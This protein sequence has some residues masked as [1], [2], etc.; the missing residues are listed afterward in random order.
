[1]SSKKQT[2]PK[3]W[4]NAYT[5]K[6]GFA[7]SLQRAGV[8]L[9]PIVFFL[10]IPLFFAIVYL[11]A[12]LENVQAN[13]FN[14]SNITGT[15][16]GGII[17]IL[18]IIFPL[19]VLGHLFKTAGTFLKSFYNLTEAMDIKQILN[20]RVFGRTPLPPPLS[21]VF[22]F[23]TVTAKNGKLDPQENWQT[24]IG[25]P[26]KLK[27]EPGYAIYLE[28]GNRFSR[29]V[30]QGNSFLELHETVK[31][32]L[33]TGP[34]S[35]NFSVSAWTRDGIHVVIKAKGEYFLGSS[36]RNKGEENILF[37]YDPA[38]A[39]KAVEETFS[40][41]RE[42]HEWLKAVV[43]K[44]QGAFGE[45]ISNRYLDEIFIP[46]VNG[47]QLLSTTTMNNLLTD[48]KTSLQK[49]GVYLSHLQ[50]TDVE[51]PE[52]IK[53]QRIKIW[54]TGHQTYA[55]VTES[56]V[57]AYQLLSQKQ[58]LAEMLRDLVFTLASGLER[59]ESTNFPEKL[60]ASIYTVLNQ[61]MKGPQTHSNSSKKTPDGIDTPDLEFKFSDDSE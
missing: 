46:S 50:I 54:E 1:M 3:D 6:Q 27:I 47:G 2:E 44:T 61:G 5:E 58:A 41:G 34:Q 29:V 55:T 26:V 17:F 60:L 43:G 30:G 28:R 19:I 8:L 32:I 12:A 10:I 7:D 9:I 49:S 53:H 20:L 37:P 39:R 25:G 33:N 40:N 4:Q 18:T 14:S 57:K 56:E 13:N 11:A 31:T 21:S 22:K 16:T 45:Y 42:G 59:T 52:P 48:I 23:P 35:E 38:S 24:K 36:T 15:I 51:L